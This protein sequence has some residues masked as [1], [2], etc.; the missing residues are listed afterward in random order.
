MTLGLLLKMALRSLGRNRRRS[1]ITI[2]AISLGLALLIVASGIGDGSHA[3][4]VDTGVGQM[5]GH[6]VVQAPGYQK[7]PEPTKALAR[8]DDI[9]AELMEVLP[10]ARL[11]SRVFLNGLLTS[12]SSSAGVALSAVRPDAERLVNDFHSKVVEGEYLSDDLQQ[13]VLGATLADNLD[14][15]LGDKVVLMTQHNGD[16]ESRLFRVCGLFRIGIDEM[17]AFYAQV[18]IEAAQELLGL[19]DGVSQLSLH[20]PDV[21]RTQR[22]THRARKALA[23]FDVEVLSW[24]KALPELYE[25]VLLDEAGMYVFILFIAFIVAMGILNTVLMSVLERIREFGVVLSLGLSPRSLAMLVMTEGFLLGLV[26]VMLG[27][28]LGVLGN[29]PMQ[30]HGLDMTSMG[31]SIE[32]AG[33]PME[34]FIKARLSPIK[35]S[36]FAVVSLAL[37]ILCSLYPAWKAAR[38]Q[39]IEAMRQH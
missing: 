18:H 11:V 12:P 9:H 27:V 22:A 19:G 17:D 34:M 37:T 4:L 39:P 26:A 1:I 31:E 14:V 7:N 24:M 3:Q 29:W 5:A 38:L 23:G 10:E 6:V 13:I 35:V 33:V 25:F 20:L 15:G 32:A 21:R 28:V 2:T 30:T 8:V 36:I 16:I